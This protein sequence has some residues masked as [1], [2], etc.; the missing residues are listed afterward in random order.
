M[1]QCASRTCYK[2]VYYIPL[3]TSQKLAK[4][5]GETFWNIIQECC[6]MRNIQ[7]GYETI[8]RKQMSDD[9]GFFKTT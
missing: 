8:T 3:I 5:S 7:S 4:T 2:T 9:L 6:H 1:K